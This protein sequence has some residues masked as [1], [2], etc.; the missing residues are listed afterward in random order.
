MFLRATASAEQSYFLR[1]FYGKMFQDNKHQE[2]QSNVTTE[3]SSRSA[4]TKATLKNF[5]K[6]TKKVQRRR[7]L[8]VKLILQIETRH[9]WRNFPVNLVRFFRLAIM[10]I[11]SQRLVVILF[12][13]EWMY[14]GYKLMESLHNSKTSNQPGLN[15]YSQRIKTQVTNGKTYPSWFDFKEGCDTAHIVLIPWFTPNAEKFHTNEYCDT[16]SCF[17]PRSLLNDHCTCCNRMVTKVRSQQA[18]LRLPFFQK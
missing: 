6:F 15:T 12:L 13:L 17:C 11:T 9:N 4:D 18:S 8:K 7:P 16:R 10:Q 2:C 14:L 1:I 3:T 5:A